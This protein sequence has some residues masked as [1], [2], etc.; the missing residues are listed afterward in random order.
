MIQL[1]NEVGTYLQSSGIGSLS[2]GLFIGQMPN[3]PPTCTSVLG[4]GGVGIGEAPMEFRRE[5]FQILNRDKS[6]QSAATQAET[7]YNL[8]AGKWNVLSTIKG[9]IIPDHPPG[10]Y[11]RDNNNMYVFT[12]N[13]RIFTITSTI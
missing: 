2:V 9:R 10:P 7:V 12:N 3:S 8:L 13:F 11:Y 6:F 4:Q 1:I 5:T